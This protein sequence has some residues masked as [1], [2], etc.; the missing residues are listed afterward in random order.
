MKH[1]IGYIIFAALLVLVLI[2]A[3]SQA[4]VCKV[5]QQLIDDAEGNALPAIRF[6]DG[7]HYNGTT[8]EYKSGYRG[9]IEYLNYRLIGIM[10]DILSLEDPDPIIILQG[11]H[12]PG[13]YLNWE[14]PEKCCYERMSILNAYSLPQS[15]SDGLYPAISPV[16][17]FR[18]IVNTCFGAQLALLEDRSNFSIW[19]SPYDLHD[20][21]GLEGMC[22]WQI[23]HAKHLFIARIQ[24]ALRHCLEKPV[25][26]RLRCLLWGG[27]RACCTKHI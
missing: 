1:R 5:A 3:P 11:D 18:Y 15:G 24:A 26:F 10:N 21:S 7:N 12:G 6:E 2:W 27:T 9:Q 17:T 20:V 23:E 4:E 16:N 22:G 25:K 13:A 14:R 8:E 19:N